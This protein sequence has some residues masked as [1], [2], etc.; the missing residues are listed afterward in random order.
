MPRIKVGGAAKTSP[1]QRHVVG[2]SRWLWLWATASVGAAM[3]AFLVGTQVESPHTQAIANAAQT[4]SVT[5]AVETR[6]LT[7]DASQTFGKVAAGQRVDIGPVG[8]GAA[9]VT[10]ALVAPGDHVAPGQ[11]VAE[12]SGR[13]IIALDLPFAL[14]RDLTPGSQGRDVQA[15]QAALGELGLY[16]GPVDG[17]YGAVTAQAVVALY[18][19]AQVSPPTAPSDAITALAAARRA[20]AAAQDQA[21]AAQDQFAAEQQ[22]VAAGQGATGDGGGSVAGQELTAPDASAVEAARTAVAAAQAD[23]DAAETRALVPLPQAEVVRLSPDGA[24]VVAVAAVGT[25][26][27]GGGSGGEGQSGAQGATAS[28]AAVTLVVGSPTVSARVSVAKAALFA[29][30]AT[31]RVT[32]VADS[33]ATSAGRVAAVSEF[34]SSGTDDGGPPGYDVTIGLD[35]GAGLADGAKVTIEADGGAPTIQGTAVPLTA[36]RSDNGVTYVVL[37]DADARSGGSR[38]DVEVRGTADGYAVVAGNLSDGDRVV[39]TAP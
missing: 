22:R 4:L 39:V 38:V 32:S 6:Q 12:V 18:Q 25:Q 15:V 35:T 2:R 9:V 31:V 1:A 36:L 3:A 5:A 34:K 8:G 23:L 14:Y 29:Q 28:I 21:A 10:A 27:A 17:F 19:R 33:A 37:A 26:L 30:G 24:K 20:L 7:T 16:G 13:T 11:A